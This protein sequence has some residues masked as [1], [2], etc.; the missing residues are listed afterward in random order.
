MSTGDRFN[1]PQGMAVMYGHFPDAESPRN[2]WRI[3]EA[4]PPQ[5]TGFVSTPHLSTAA[6]A[7]QAMKDRA[8]YLEG[9]LAQ[10]AAWQEELDL[11]RR[12]LDA[13]S[14]PMASEPGSA[15]SSE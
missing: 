4:L 1:W 9:Q 11:I 5:G 10:A 2:P 14:K 12:V 6:Q 7:I 15:E 8:A 13:A 3:P